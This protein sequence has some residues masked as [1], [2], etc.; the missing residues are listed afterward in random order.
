MVD[1]RASP[2][3][4]AI[5]Q[6]IPRRAAPTVGTR[7]CLEADARRQRPG[8][9]IEA[10]LCI[11]GAG[12][13][14]LSLAHALLGS[15][16]QVVVLESG[17]RDFDRVAQA[18]NE[19][20]VVGSAYGDLL[21]T[22]QRQVGGTANAWNSE[23]DGEVAAKFVPLDPI[24]FVERA[25]VPLGGWPFGREELDRW[26]EQAHALCGI[27]P[28]DYR[29]DAW[30]SEGREPLRLDG[31]LLT[32]GLYRFGTDAPFVQRIPAA[33]AAAPNVT[34][35]TRATVL[36]LVAGADGGRVVAARVAG[37]GG[38]QFE[39]RASRFVLAAGA[40]E[41]AR[42]L[43]ASSGADPQGLGNRYGWVGRCFM[44]HPRDFSMRLVPARGD[45]F[46]ALRFY[47]QHRMADGSTIL[48]RLA[49]REDA[50]RQ[51]ALLNA[52]VTLLPAGV[53]RAGGATGW[54]ERVG[55]W[56]GR[57]AT[58]GQAYP[59]GGAGWSADSRRGDAFA[60]VRLLVNLEQAPHPENRVVLVDG[61]DRLG[62]R[63]VQVRW[64]WRPDEQDRLER[65]RGLLAKELEGAGFGR[66][67]RAA[68]AVPDPRAHHHA[69]TTRMHDDP[70]FGVV[71][72][73]CRVHGTANLFVAGAS[74]FPTAGFANPT[75]TIVALALR[76]A[77]RL[78]PPG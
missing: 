48:G 34:L 70:R 13:A 6:A 57:A 33:L 14:G 28:F 65:L 58:G 40:I 4:Y 29:A 26:Y 9:T 76:L 62:V 67:E 63:R 20:Q 74:V 68:Q 21:Q 55:R 23:V 17:G 36:E 42:L 41:N 46:D 75:L 44:E 2:R 47:D 32:T 69:G 78:R 19:A 31:T 22:R 5:A 54:R 11:V 35:L 1:G 77:Q 3:L 50:M 7:A 49:L 45:W 37:S 30:R 71:D 18:L 52:S 8:D 27:G 64:H 39:V 56:L 12:P 38:A 10:D 43:L 15:G 61:R 53:S 24:D 51:H 59:R 25:D 66:I 60:F 16:L 72:R 73:D